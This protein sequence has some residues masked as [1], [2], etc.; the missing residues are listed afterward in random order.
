[1]RL[2]LALGIALMLTSGCAPKTTVVLLPD[3]AGNV[4]SVEVS[5]ERSR[6]MLDT[7]NAY[8]E[9]WLFDTP[10]EVRLMSADSIDHDFATALRAEPPPPKSF[11][12]YFHSE[13]TTLNRP[14]A[15][16]F[17]EIVEA[18]RTEPQVEVN[19]IGHTDT[20]G[21]DSYNWNLSRRRAE[22]IRK[23]LVKSGI[24]SD[25]IFISFHGENDPLIPTAD[26]V[27]EPRNR[28]VEIFLR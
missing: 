11:H 4:G 3:E 17:P 20:A 26:E 14:S 1:M 24:D 27:H 15:S 13:T 18:I 21:D 2:V 9:V 28:R 25:I 10:S 12:L 19:V 7:P 23:K 5:T 8:T 16:R 22:R 6:Q